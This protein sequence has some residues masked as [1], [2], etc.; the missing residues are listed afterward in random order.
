MQQ[1]VP[2][3]IERATM[4][5]AQRTQIGML[6]RI[7]GRRLARLTTRSAAAIPPAP[8]GERTAERPSNRE[9][10]VLQL[11]ADGFAN[12]EI[13]QRLSVSEETVK[14]HVRHLLAKLDARNRAHAVSIA[15][16]RG[17]IT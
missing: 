4:D 6:Y 15:I 7:D 13:G 11:V 1:I 12:R 16:R 9:I 3:G 10:A 2:F 17:F 8:P 5:A 14:S